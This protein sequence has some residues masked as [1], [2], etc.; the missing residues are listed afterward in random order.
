VLRSEELRNWSGE[1][2]EGVE[3]MLAT[4]FI[5]PKRRG[6]GRSGRRDGGGRWTL[7]VSVLLGLETT[8]GAPVTGRG[9]EEV[10]VTLGMREAK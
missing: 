10:T 7:N 6:D 8:S 5:G 4:H 2:K 1:W 3:A 9:V